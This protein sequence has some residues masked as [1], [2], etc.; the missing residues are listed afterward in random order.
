M[1]NGAYISIKVDMGPF[2]ITITNHARDELEP[3][4]KA[5]LQ[6]I[7]SN[8]EKISA[9]TEKYK[10]S[11]IG[12]KDST[13]RPRSEARVSSGLSITEF[14]RTADR[15]KGTDIGLAV[16]Y[17]LFKERQLDVIN[18]KDF[19]NAY[20]E[21]RIARPRNPTDVL[22]S[23]VELGKMMAAGEKDGFKGFAITQTGEK[24]VD[25]WLAEKS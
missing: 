13:V 3:A 16:A 9:L 21:A 20:D 17:Y 19:V 4:L 23:L 7:E 22:N 14:V 11:Q 6:A 10:S 24:E 5:S 18:S 8:S 2:E 15:T 1:K 25:E 12:K